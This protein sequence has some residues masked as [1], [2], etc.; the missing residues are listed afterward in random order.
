VQDFGNILGLMKIIIKIYW[1]K[2][3]VGIPLRDS[4]ETLGLIM[5]LSWDKLPIYQLVDVFHSD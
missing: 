5:G 3:S 2:P 4:C 1:D